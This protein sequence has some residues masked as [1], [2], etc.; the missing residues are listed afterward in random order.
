MFIEIPL[1][2][3]LYN[4]SQTVNLSGVFYRLRFTYSTR[5]QTY[6]MDILTGSGQVLESG[7]P[8]A[9]DVQLNRRIVAEMPG[10][11]FF[12]STDGSLSYAG[13]LTL[14]TKVKLFYYTEDN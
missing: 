14:G 6:F 4:F 2:T 1:K 5:K 11:L 7:L 8:C 10:V 3:N 9:V 13:R 12:Q